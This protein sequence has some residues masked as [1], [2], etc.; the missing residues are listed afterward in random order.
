MSEGLESNSRAV[1]VIVCTTITVAMAAIVVVLR[2]I[3]RWKILN[4]LGKDDWCIAIAL[5]S[6][7]S[8]P[9]GPTRASHNEGADT[10]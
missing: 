2:L 7:D 10:R 3:T 8:P 5:V 4:F 6:L 1:S 9:P